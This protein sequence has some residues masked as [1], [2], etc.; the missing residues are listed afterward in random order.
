MDA[1]P[2]ENDASRSPFVYPSVREGLRMGLLSARTHGRIWVTAFGY[3]VIV[4]AVIGVVSEWLDIGPTDL[5]FRVAL[6][7]VIMGYLM[8]SVWASQ[9]GS[10]VSRTEMKTYLEARIES[11]TNFGLAMGVL[12]TLG[13]VALGF[14]LI[15]AVNAWE[16]G[17]TWP[18][19]VYGLFLV[20]LL[21]RVG[22]AAL[23]VTPARVVERLEGTS[24]LKRAWV[25]SR[26]ST[27]VLGVLVLVGVVIQLGG[28]LLLAAILTEELV[29]D[30]VY[31]AVVAPIASSVLNIW[32]LV[33]SGPAYAITRERAEGYPRAEAE[34]DFARLFEE[35]EAAN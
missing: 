10:S 34:S 28:V 22:N 25:L 15:P 23:I 11:F 16:S 21:V 19:A 14:A 27:G 9:L 4:E 17:R 24:A 1:P 5:L 33:A 12:A 3:L 30:W 18:V 35:V 32:W 20:V 2:S 29:S 7:V 26:R 6:V 13:A 31:F 8:P